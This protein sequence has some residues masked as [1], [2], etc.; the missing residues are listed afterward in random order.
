MPVVGQK[1]AHSASLSLTV[2]GGDTDNVAVADDHRPS[3]ISADG[4]EQ[5]PYLGRYRGAGRESAG[6]GSMRMP[7]YADRPARPR[8]RHARAESRRSFLA[9][10]T[11]RRA[12]RHPSASGGS[13]SLKRHLRGSSPVQ[14]LA[15]GPAL[16]SGRAGRRGQSPHPA[17]H[18]RRPWRHTVDANTIWTLS[19]GVRGGLMMRPRTGN[20]GRRASRRAPPRGPSSRASLNNDPTRR[21]LQKS[22]WVRDQ[23]L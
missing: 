1:T 3:M 17:V 9:W 6:T 20:P 18:G 5:P 21:D 7:E 2:E 14:L 4:S 10:S 16:R 23:G 11:R 8:P 12:S 22:V 19:G 13:V 15:S